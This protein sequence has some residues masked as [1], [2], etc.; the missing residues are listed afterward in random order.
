M[1]LILPDKSII[2]NPTVNDVANQVTQLASK[3][4]LSIRV[5]DKNY[6]TVGK[7]YFNR[8]YIGV[9]SNGEPTLKGRHFLDDEVVIQIASHYLTGNDTWRSLTEWDEVKVGRSLEPV[10]PTTAAIG[11]LVAS[12]IVALSPW[13]LASYLQMMEVNQVELQ[14]TLLFSA[15]VLAIPNGIIT[16]INRRIE[17]TERF[18]AGAVLVL[19]FFMMFVGLIKIIAC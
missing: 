17:G 6:V 9:V 18:K 3:K 19:T 13:S 2:V 7:F 15:A 10:I 5:D 12:I 14:L 16:A 8:L 4:S 11:L 1:Q